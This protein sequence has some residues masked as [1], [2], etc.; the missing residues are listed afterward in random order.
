[1]EGKHNKIKLSKEIGGIKY[2]KVFYTSVNIK[3]IQLDTDYKVDTSMNWKITY[4]QEDGSIE[5][6]NGSYLVT[7]LA[8]FGKSYCVKQQKEYNKDTTLRLAFTNCATERI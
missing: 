4:E 7:G 8:G 2:N 1:M 3:D 6:P 5:T